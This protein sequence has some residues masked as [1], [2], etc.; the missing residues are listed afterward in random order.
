MGSRTLLIASLAGALLAPAAPAA[1][2]AWSGGASAPSTAG[3]GTE[4]GAP[5]ARAT[6]KRPV[7]GLVRVTPRT[8]TEGGA[9]PRIA[10]R[11]DQR[12]VPRVAAR[13]VFTPL[14]GK[15]RALRLDLG[16]V[17]TGRVLRPAWPSGRTLTAGRYVVR[18]HARGPGGSVL[19]RRAHASGRA[20]LTVRKAPPPPAPP[21]PPPTP[22]P[23][24][25]GVFPVAGPHSFG[26]DDA[27]FGAAR[28][29]HVHQ[30]QDVVA[31]GGTPVVAPVAG[32]IAALDRQPGGAGWYV[33]ENGADG[34]AYFF[35]HCQANSWAVTLGQAVS[36]GQRL[37]AVGATG[38]ATG[39]HLHFEI[40]VGG[41][42]AGKS[43]APIDPLPQLLAWDGRG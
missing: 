34:R 28:D 37:C 30:G 4:Y 31:A 33:V 17:R 27:R 7:A 11:I 43:S 26:G 38:D 14:R 18:V 41:W 22:V 29:G 20:P 36:A 16:S 1:A 9:P 42:H 39:P 5:L 21:A 24:S 40:W 8:V 35:A 12:G 23:S 25:S 6:A 3:G 13:I 2:A 19:R 15:G 32:T 10:L